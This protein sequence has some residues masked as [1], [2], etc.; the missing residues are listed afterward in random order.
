MS[1][2]TSTIS[3]QFLNKA[4]EYLSSAEAFLKAEV[5]AFI[6]E[7]LLWNF[8]ESLVFLVVGVLL[9]VAAGV[10]FY[11]PIKAKYFEDHHGPMVI[12]GFMFFLIGTGMVISNGLDMIKIKVAPR[13]FLLQ[14]VKNLTR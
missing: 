13:V 6:Q 7:L 14:E 5:P 11:K 10:L 1:D 12:F 8:Y 9:L 3:D 2:Q 4:L